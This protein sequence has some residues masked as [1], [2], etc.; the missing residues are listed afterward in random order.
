MGTTKSKPKGSN[1]GV[2]IEHDLNDRWSINL[3]GAYNTSLTKEKHGIRG[4]GGRLG[5]AYW[6]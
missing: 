2:M 3:G 1:Y 6:F 4:Y 5:C